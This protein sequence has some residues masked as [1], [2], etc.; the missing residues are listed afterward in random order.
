M[1]RFP[2]SPSEKGNAIRHTILIV[3]RRKARSA[4]AAKVFWTQAR[5]G[6]LLQT[7]GAHRAVTGA[8]VSAPPHSSA[9]G[10]CHRR[11]SN[12]SFTKCRPNRSPGMPAEDRSESVICLKV[13]ALL[14][15]SSLG[16]SAGVR[17]SCE[18]CHLK[19]ALRFPVVVKSMALGS[20]A[21]SPAS[22]P[23]CDLGWV[24]QAPWVFLLSS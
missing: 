5:Q 17:A 1:K 8:Q 13:L 7:R 24:A 10:D 20:L 2:G 22:A 19:G 23:L 11:K 15:S 21:L 4:V 16:A 14:D 9:T 3:H 12:S 18:R 6:S